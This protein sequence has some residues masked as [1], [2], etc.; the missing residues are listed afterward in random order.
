Y[1]QVRARLA[2]GTIDAA[3]NNIVSYSASRHFEV[4]KVYSATEHSAPPAVVVFS[5][6]VWDQL[7]ATDQQLIR[8]AA[9]DSIAFYRTMI[10]EQEAAIRK[11][12]IESGVEFVTDVDRPAFARLLT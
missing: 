3:E 7:P 6:R 9:R 11:A 8:Q 2:A 12:L 1:A 4:A 5:K 10:D